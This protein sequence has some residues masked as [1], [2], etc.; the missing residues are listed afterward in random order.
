MATFLQDDRLSQDLIIASCYNQKPFYMISHIIEQLI[1][2]EWMKRIWSST[3]KKPIALTF[4]Y[5]N[6]SY[7]Y[8]HKIN[9]DIAD[10]SQLVYYLMRFQHNEKWQ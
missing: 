1:L 9:I 3:L 5:W 4:L 10:Q 2:V 7:D 8:N 6:S